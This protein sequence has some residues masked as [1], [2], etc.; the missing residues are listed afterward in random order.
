[1]LIIPAS[2]GRKI[3]WSICTGKGVFI[4]F[5]VHM[6]VTAEAAEAEALKKNL[7][8]LSC[9]ML[10]VVWRSCGGGKWKTEIRNPR[11]ES[12]PKDE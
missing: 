7:S 5:S 3:V 6:H 8:H 10:S 1:L 11:S 4:G 2:A 12:N 9:T